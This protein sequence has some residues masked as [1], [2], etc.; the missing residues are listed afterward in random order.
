MERAGMLSAYL[1]GYSV[2]IKDGQI[3]KKLDKVLT[4]NT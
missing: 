4:E 2:P 3:K 1:Q